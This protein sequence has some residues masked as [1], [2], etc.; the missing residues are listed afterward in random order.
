MS[1]SPP[2][3]ITK[4][5]SLSRSGSVARMKPKG[6]LIGAAVIVTAILLGLVLSIVLLFG[7]TAAAADCGPRVSDVIDSDTKVDGYAPEQLEN[8]A[9]ILSAGKA[10]NLPAKGQMIG[11]MVALGSRA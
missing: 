11:V 7:S 6:L 10:L 8:A 9:A 1:L 3:S 2:Y 5:W 4:Q